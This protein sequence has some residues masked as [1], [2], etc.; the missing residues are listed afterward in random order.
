MMNFEYVRAR[1]VADA[2]RKITAEP[3]AKFIAGV[4]NI[5]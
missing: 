5:G 3:A 1:D 4:D 2:V